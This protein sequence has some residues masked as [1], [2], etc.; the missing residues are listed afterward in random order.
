[1]CT[2][3]NGGALVVPQKL[4]VELS[5]DPAIPLLSIHLGELETYIHVKTCTQKFTAALFMMAPTVGS[6]R[7]F[8]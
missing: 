3:I 2:E 8:T 5:R 7:M 1:M 6:T 4:N